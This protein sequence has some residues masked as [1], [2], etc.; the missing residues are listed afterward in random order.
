MTN[1]LLRGVA[2]VD[3]TLARR[4]ENGDSF[5]GAEDLATRKLGEQPLSPALSR[6]LAADDDFFTLGEPQ[7]FSEMIAAEFGE[8][9]VELFQ[10]VAQRL[11]APVVLF[12]GW[13]SDSRR[14]LYL[15][16]RDAQGEPT[17]MTVDMDDTPFFAVNGPVDV[18]LAQ[19]AGFLA[20]EDVYGA[21]P[22]LY[23]E[24]RREHAALNFGGFITFA[25][26]MLSR[27]LDADDGEPAWGDEEEE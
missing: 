5:T 8:E 15:G 1:E 25:D 9:W 10:P 2:L 11:K 7:S 26:G 16:K 13:G 19:H 20:D 17:V 22:P 14:F 21:V 12:E 23:E 3:A 6:W 18:W 24:T 27:S 4:K